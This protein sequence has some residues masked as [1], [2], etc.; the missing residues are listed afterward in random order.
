MNSNGSNPH[1]ITFFNVPGSPE[2]NGS[3][4][5]IADSAWNPSGNRLVASVLEIGK[6]HSASI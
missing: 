2:Y 6:T 3:Q 4:V 5:I 1:Q